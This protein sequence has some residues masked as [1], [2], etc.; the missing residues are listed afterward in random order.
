[1]AVALVMTTARVT[2]IPT[3]PR[4]VLAQRMLVLQGQGGL[5]VPVVGTTTT[6]PTDTITAPTAKTVMLDQGATERTPCWVRR[7]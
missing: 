3:I 6:T 1:M 2:L 7:C 5:L 4:R